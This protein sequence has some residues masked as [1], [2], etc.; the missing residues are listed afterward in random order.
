VSWNPFHAPTLALLIKGG[1]MEPR[2]FEEELY[3]DMQHI[4][5]MIQKHWDNQREVPSE[6]RKEMKDKV[7]EIEKRFK[8]N[9]HLV[10]LPG[11]LTAVLNGIK[12]DLDMV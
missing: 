11:T 10:M 12:E 6:L 2:H 5:R 1:D 8:E 3:Q 4:K 9:R 7:R